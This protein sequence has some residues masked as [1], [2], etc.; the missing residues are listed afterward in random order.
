MP[1]YPESQIQTNLYTNGGEF[2]LIP[3]DYN[4]VYVGYYWKTSRNEFYTGKT[5]QNTPSE[6]LYPFLRN[7]INNITS[8][9]TFTPI[10]INNITVPL[11][12]E[13]DITNS[14]NLSYATLKPPV[15]PNTL[16]T[17]P[18]FSPTLPTNKDYEIGEFRRYFCKKTNEILYLE[19]SKD[20]HDKLVS[21]DNS[22]LW[23]LYFPFDIPWR[24]I[25]NLSKIFTINKNIVELTST[26]LNLPLFSEYLN[27]DFTK[28]HK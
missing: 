2:S 27:N 18:Y 8:T 12:Q 4:S 7:D 21:K 6:K 3:N 16:V 23:Q 5:P 13:D 15:N 28:Y 25:G 24:L 10:F 1:Y 26:Q 22:L 11:T 19:I 17:L 20:T 14:N 9:P